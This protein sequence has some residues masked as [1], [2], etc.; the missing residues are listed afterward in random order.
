[1]DM[2]EQYDLA[3]EMW[4]EIKK[5][6]AENPNVHISSIRT[7]FLMDKPVRW[8]K[9]CV[10]CNIYYDVLA[11]KCDLD[12]PLA[13]YVGRLDTDLPTLCAVRNSPYDIVQDQLAY[14]PHRL[15]ACDRII[16]ELKEAKIDWKETLDAEECSQIG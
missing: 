11:G 1:M 9:D 2:L 7:S 4:E 14:L 15:E 10:F 3:I 13:K 6:I 8:L 12:C 5:S 16:N